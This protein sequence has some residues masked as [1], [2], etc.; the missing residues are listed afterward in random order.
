MFNLA[1]IQQALGGCT[2]AKARAYLRGQPV[3]AL[4]GGCH[5]QYLPYSPKTIWDHIQD[6]YA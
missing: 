2:A 4:P 3:K 1:G 6:E 5:F